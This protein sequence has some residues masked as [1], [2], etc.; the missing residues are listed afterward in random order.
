MLRSS[1]VNHKQNKG[2]RFRFLLKQKIF[3]IEVKF[4]PVIQMASPG[5]QKMFIF[6]ISWHCLGKYFSFEFYYCKI[7]L[8]L[9]PFVADVKATVFVN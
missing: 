8:M 2:T 6:I 1:K 4:S 5:L 9:L 7:R 3:C